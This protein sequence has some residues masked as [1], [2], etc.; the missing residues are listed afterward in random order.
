MSAIAVSLA[1]AASYGLMFLGWGELF[2]RAVGLA[3]G[4]AAIDMGLG[5]AALT[6]VG[7]AL[8]AGRLAV[9]VALTVVALVGMAIALFRLGREIKQMEADDLRKWVRSKGLAA[10]IVIGAMVFVG[11]TVVPPAVMNVGDD[12]QK[13]LAH[14]ARMLQTGTF[15]GSPLNALGTESPGGQPFLQSFIAAVAPFPYVNAFDALFCFGLCMAMA[16]SLAGPARQMAAIGVLGAIGVAVIEPQNANISALYSGSALVFALY[17]LLAAPEEIARSSAGRRAL[18]AGLIAAAM[19]VLKPTFL[20][21]AAVMIGAGAVSIA[22]SAKS[23]SAAIRWSAIA[24]G[25]VLLG[26]LPWIA[27]YAP[28]L[29]ELSSV[30]V[31]GS[32]TRPPSMPAVNLLSSAPLPWGAS[33]LAYTLAMTFPA[34]AGALVLLRWR[35]LSSGERTGAVTLA[36]A[37]LGALAAYVFVILGLGSRFAEYDTAVRYMTPVVVAVVPASIVLGARFLIAGIAETPVFARTS[38]YTAL[39]IAALALFVPPLAQRVAQASEF[40]NML[41]FRYFAII[42]E[43]R[44][45]YSQLTA[46]SQAVFVRRLQDFTPPGAAILVLMNTPFLF[47]FRRNVIYDATSAGIHAP[48]AH[49]PPV[50]YVIWDYGS[51]TVAMRNE[52]PSSAFPGADRRAFGLVKVLLDVT[53][54]GATGA[55]IYNDGKFAVFRAS[56]L[57]KNWP[58]YP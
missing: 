2:R 54:A 14:L 57:P 17:A 35:H 45:I 34:V 44:S 53:K 1:I 11:A 48:W 20:M 33:G 7:G 16:A 18:A 31:E 30:A 40:H 52:L 26:L 23:F 22:V 42:P 58:N 41:A 37:A 21:I 36:V 6:T 24:T 15:Y 9:P 46:P 27:V 50:E 56:G 38:A 4:R 12:L 55:L 19:I 51:D 5:I 32:I 13:Y 8:N 39:A 49:I 25:G 10:V 3:R 28:Y 47:D 43:Y 29:G